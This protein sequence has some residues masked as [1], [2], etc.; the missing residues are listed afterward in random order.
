VVSQTNAGGAYT[1]I[2]ISGDDAPARVNRYIVKVK[3]VAR[4][5][6]LAR[7]GTGTSRTPF[8]NYALLN[9]IF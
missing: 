2:G 9:R 4:I 5:N 3:Q 8:T 6:R 1:A 7:I